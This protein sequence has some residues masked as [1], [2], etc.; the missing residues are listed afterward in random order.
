MCTLE[1]VGLAVFAVCAGVA[2]LVIAGAIAF[3]V[4][5]VWREGR[6]GGV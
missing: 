1:Q 3:G 4:Y 5:Q 2:L 6:K